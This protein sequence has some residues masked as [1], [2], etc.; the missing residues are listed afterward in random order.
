MTPFDLELGDHP[1]ARRVLPRLDAL[2]RARARRAGGRTDAG[3]GLAAAAAAPSPGILV[4]LSGGPDSTALLLLADAWGRRRGAPVVA[5]HLNH[6]LRGGEADGDERFCR[7]LCARLGVPLHVAAADPRPLARRRGRGLEEA[8]RRLRR[9]FLLGVLAREPRL[10]AI[11]TAHHRDDQVETVLM[12]LFRGAGPDGLRGI[13]PLAGPFI[14]PLLEVGRGDLVAF[15]ED[16]GQPYRLDRSNEE[17]DATRTRV[18]RELLPLARDIF[19]EGCA[20]GPARLSALLAGD[21][22][23]LERRAALALRRLREGAPAGAGP[24]AS[25]HAPGL[26]RLPPALGRRVLRRLARHAGA[27]RD[28]GLVHLQAVLAW[29][30]EARSGSSLDLPHGW[31]AVREFDRLVL[32]PPGSPLPDPR[33]TYRLEVRSKPESSARAS[34]QDGDAGDPRTAQAGEWRLECPAEALQGPVRLRPWRPGD[35]IAL[36]GLAGRKKVSDL[37]QERR[38]GVTRRPGILVVEDDAGLL[39]V[40]GV[41]PAARTSLLPGT[42]RTVTIAVAPEAPDALGGKDRPNP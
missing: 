16:A 14:H 31:R 4:A 34:A 27:G 11:A 15:L 36:P 42:E 24:D 35:R 10:A 41:A 28:L 20:A 33:G 9:R 39:W 18:R 38:I 32:C 21:L 13:R 30:P 2:V 26:L 40:V 5:A 17:G 29:L 8:G 7:D 12:R 6:G 19:G 25:L 23:L 37:L 3:P 1:L 22:A